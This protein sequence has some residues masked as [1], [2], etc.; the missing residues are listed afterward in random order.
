MKFKLVAKWDASIHMV[1][2]RWFIFPS[3]LF[4][5]KLSLRKEEWYALKWIMQSQK[6]NRPVELDPETEIEEKGDI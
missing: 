5:G 4:A 6:P 1:V 2:V 3:G